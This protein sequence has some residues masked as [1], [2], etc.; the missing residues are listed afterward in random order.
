MAQV[1]AR[2]AMRSFAW[3]LATAAALDSREGSAGFARDGVLPGLREAVA[4]LAALEVLAPC[5]VC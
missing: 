1:H 2:G 5:S 3:A 4:E